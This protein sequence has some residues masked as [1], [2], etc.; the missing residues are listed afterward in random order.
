M[1]GVRVVAYRLFSA[2]YLDRYAVS[3]F[4]AAKTMSYNV[5]GDPEQGPI[6]EGYLGF[7]GDHGGDL[8]IRNLRIDTMPGWNTAYAWPPA[9]TG[10][11]ATR[12]PASPRVR[13]AR[14][15]G[16]VEV[17]LP[18]ESVREA[19]LSDL[20]GRPRGIAQG[21]TDGK[22]LFAAPRESGVYLFRYRDAAGLRRS[23][24]IWISP[25]R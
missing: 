1:N 13:M 15:G 25:L 7:Q 24:K 3:K 17:S 8:E 20:S 22:V 5:Q 11:A 2:D 14:Y 21:T 4:G 6:R 16:R 23:I 9:L 10:A 18:G 19:S 12:A